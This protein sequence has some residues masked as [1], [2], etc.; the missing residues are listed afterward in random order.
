MCPWI[1]SFDLPM[2]LSVPPS[3]TDWEPL[4]GGGGGEGAAQMECAG[5]ARPQ[6][7][8]EATWEK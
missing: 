5:I 3:T 8:K 7:L 4:S 6:V 2:N 1:T